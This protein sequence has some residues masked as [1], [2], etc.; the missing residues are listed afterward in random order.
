MTAATALVQVGPR[1][2]EFQEIAVPDHLDAGALLVRV[3]ANGLC[4]S[5]VD[6]YDGTDPYFELGDAS[7]YP[8]IMGHEVVG[9]IEAMGAATERR[10]GVKLGD[11]VAIDPYNSCGQCE[12]CRQGNRMYCSG[13]PTRSSVL[14][15]IPTTLGPGLWGGYAT[16]IYVHPNTDVYGFPSSVSPLDATLWNPLAGGIQWAVM[17][18]GLRP[19]A[20]VAV[21]GCGQRGLACLVAVKS[22]GAG[23]VIV[24][25]LHQD[26]HKLDLAL[27]LG[28]D[29]AVDVE[30]DSLLDQA[31][32]LTDSQGF[33]LVVDTTPHSFQPVRD[34]IEMLRPRGTL[35]TV[36]IKTSA[37]PDF[38]I[39][40]VTLKGLRL[41]GSLGQSH[42][43]YS[44]AAAL[45]A[46]SSFPLNKM[47][48]HV[49]GFDR[50]EHAIELL[51]GK[52][53]HEKPI[54]VVVTPTRS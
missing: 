34:G 32:D 33:D 8:R 19:G 13:W 3:E 4:A 16:H 42:E 52:H 36:G 10:A 50:L 45:V 51:Q 18:P 35:V 40:A 37:M 44:R 1:Q 25:G 20:K 28:A 47:R 5:D 41:L 54:N 11:R 12:H 48:T 49:L 22:A 14:G 46:D 26:R 7:R 21:L 17:N 29:A 38:P 39:D 9:V 27:E 2:L 15:H 6:Q 53:P 43:A 24:S 30:E 23:K 31:R